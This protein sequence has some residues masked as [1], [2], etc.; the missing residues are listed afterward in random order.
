MLDERNY[1]SYKVLDSGN[2]RPEKGRRIR[3]QQKFDPNKIYPQKKSVKKEK[4]KRIV[5]KTKK[6]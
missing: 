5:E 2:K 1:T 6:M 3:K 4:P